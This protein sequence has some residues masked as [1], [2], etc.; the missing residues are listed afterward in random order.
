MQYVS[1][2]KILLSSLGMNPYQPKGFWL[3]EEGKSVWK[4]PESRILDDHLLEM[5][6][7]S[8]FIVFDTLTMP[9]IHRKPAL[10]IWLESSFASRVK[11]AKVSHRGRTRFSTQELEELIQ[12]KDKLARSDFHQRYGFD[13][14]ADRSVFHLILDISD[15]ISEATL[16]SSIRSITAVQSLVRPAVGWHLTGQSSFKREF[17]TA[18]KHFSG[19][20]VRCS[21]SL[22]GAST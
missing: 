21:P 9:W 20:L 19:T 22:I 5:E 15:C 17:Q 2:S 8:D 18:L 4:T 12:K 10:T 6:E 11:K 16:L 1:A 7:A 13:L 3:T 14:F